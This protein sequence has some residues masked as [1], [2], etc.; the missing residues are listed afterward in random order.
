MEREKGRVKTNG[1]THR[2]TDGQIGS[3]LSAEASV[4]SFW[5]SLERVSSTAVNA[6]K[7][8]LNSKSY[9]KSATRSKH[10]MQ[11]GDF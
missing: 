2:H 1:Q 3:S 4:R 7:T 9:S 8:L 6:F 5:V 10:A 11:C